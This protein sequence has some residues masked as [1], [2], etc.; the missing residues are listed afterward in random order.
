M[1]LV[2]LTGQGEERLSQREAL[3][4]GILPLLFVNTSSYLVSVCHVNFGKLIFKSRHMDKIKSINVFNN[5]MYQSIR[6]S[7]L[8]KVNKAAYNLKESFKCNHII[9]LR[10]IELII[11]MSLRRESLRSL[12]KTQIH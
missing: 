1:S 3:G 6:F 2:L 11:Y 8:T 10:E 5:N 12:R 4:F 9:L 7:M